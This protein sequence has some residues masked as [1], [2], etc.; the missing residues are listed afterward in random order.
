MCR[1]FNVL[2][3]LLYLLV[4]TIS[5]G[6]NNV[7][8]VLIEVCMLGREYINLLL[9]EFHKFWLLFKKWICC[10]AF[11]NSFHTCSLIVFHMP[12]TVR[13]SLRGRQNQESVPFIFIFIFLSLSLQGG[14]RREWDKK[15]RE[16]GFALAVGWPLEIVGSE[17]R[18]GGSKFEGGTEY[19]Q[20]LKLDRSLFCGGKGKLGHGE[21]ERE[22]VDDEII[23]ID[24]SVLS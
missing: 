11:S 20:N 18:T 17:V 1:I 13:G 2:G 9:A 24:G 14:G 3:F 6:L 15:Y 4:V 22:A 12:D 7:I 23:L 8:L 21:W 19:S 5:P 16:E 10:K